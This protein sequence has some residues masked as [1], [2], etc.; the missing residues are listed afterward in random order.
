MASPC[1]IGAEPI[2]LRP[3]KGRKNF[4]NMHWSQRLILWIQPYAAVRRRTA[5]YGAV[6]CTGLQG[7]SP[8]VPGILLTSCKNK[9]SNKKTHC[10]AAQVLLGFD[11]ILH[12]FSCFSKMTSEV[13]D[14]GF[15]GEQYLEHHLGLLV[16]CVRFSKHGRVLLHC[17]FVSSNTSVCHQKN[18]VPFSVFVVT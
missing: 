5:P 2:R 10:L 12:P 13:S 14:S 4:P 18:R 6:R 8:G 16:N 15:P 9:N 7:W 1:R 17:G 11:I 3:T